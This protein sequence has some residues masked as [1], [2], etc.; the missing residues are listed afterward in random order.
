MEAQQGNLRGLVTDEYESSKKISD[1]LIYLA[2][3]LTWSVRNNIPYRETFLGVGGW[4]I[5]RDFVY[6]MKFVFRADDRLYKKLKLYDFPQKDLQYRA[7]NL[8]M[9]RL[10]SIPPVRKRM[11]RDMT[12]IMVKPFLKYS[13]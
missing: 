10:F 5:F 2:D 6:K 4:K 9:P 3:D 8:F 11:Q 1:L 12:K 7:M 13:K